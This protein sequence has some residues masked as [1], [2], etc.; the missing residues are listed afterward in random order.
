MTQHHEGSTVAGVDMSPVPALK[1]YNTAT[2]P[3]DSEADVQRVH[4][5][6]N[7]NYTV[8]VGT[9][10]GQWAVVTPYG[11]LWHVAIYETHELAVARAKQ[12]SWVEG[13]R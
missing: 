12:L 9:I 10:D 6:H 8:G 7:S 3:Y 1:R 13:G 2:V 4:P 5:E 11:N